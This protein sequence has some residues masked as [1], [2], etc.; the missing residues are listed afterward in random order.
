MYTSFYNLHSKPF[1]ISSD[2]AFMWFGEKHK[3][4]LA[5]LKYGILDNK[6]FLLLTGDVGTGKTSLIN[7]LIES[8]SEDIV[9]ASVPDP[10]LEKMDFL[11]FIALAFGMGR[12][13]STK[14]TFLVHFKQFL[15][16]AHEN[17]K[18]VLLII[19]ESQ[20]LTQEILEEIRLLSNIEKTDAKL[21]NIF[22]VGQNEFNEILNQQQNRAVRQRLTLNYNIDPL[23]PDETAEYIKHRLQVAGTTQTIFDTEA[24]QEIFMYSGG[25]PRRINIICDHCLLSGYVN[26]K[27]EINHLIVKECA[28]ELKIPAHVS[29]R[30]INGFAPNHS[31]PATMIKAQPFLPLPKQP[32]P[33]P[34]TPRSPV[35]WV[36]V[37]LVVF[38]IA[39]F[40]IFPVQFKQSVSKAN[41]RLI[42]L[43]K[44]IM[45]L[46][47]ISDPAPENLKPMPKRNNDETLNSPKPKTS[48]IITKPT[49]AQI[50]KPVETPA[51][52]KILKPIEAIKPNE[53]IELDEPS[54]QPIQ[55]RIQDES[56]SQTSYTKP[57]TNPAVTEPG[58]VQKPV[59]P[60]LPVLPEEKVIVRFKYDTND[61]SKPGYENLKTFADSLVMNP[62]ARVLISGH[63]DSEGNIRYNQKLSEFRA[64]IVRSFLLGKGAKPDQIKIKGVGSENPVESNNTA[65]GRM[66]NRRVEIEVL[67]VE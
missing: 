33:K 63:T 34:K 47:Q 12:E 19:D 16:E 17:N 5:T 45:Q 7:S 59:L 57:L 27:K 51:P 55:E 65:W 42:I 64:N 15:M 6:G 66:M 24:V 43:K 4:A 18:K 53:A 40:S 8:L 22:F 25:F 10:S 54:V 37:F 41:D 49:P 48:I 9:V 52:G 39:W 11:N 67:G 26:A 31:R 23:T 38:F 35:K 14:G 21:I 13:F 28:R 32:K 20:L 62:E 44:H 3:E 61:F 29:N 1:Q 30:D 36:L 56:S 58:K 2:P 50:I 46:S 60:V